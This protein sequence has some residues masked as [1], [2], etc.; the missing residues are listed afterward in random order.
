MAGYFEWHPPDNDDPI[1]FNQQKP[2]LLRDRNLTASNVSIQQSQT[3]PFQV[4]ASFLNPQIESRTFALSV[5]IADPDGENV[6]EFREELA[7]K[8]IVEPQRDE[9]PE[10]GRLV[11]KGGFREFDLELK[12]LPIN[13]PQFSQITFR[14]NVID[15]DLEFFAPYPF[16]TKLEDETAQ[17]ELTGGLEFPLEFEIEFEKFE[18]DDFVINNQGEFKT[19]VIIRVYAFANSVRI[20][21]KTTNEALKFNG[22]IPDGSFLEINTSFGEK[23]VEFVDQETGERRNAIGNLSLSESDF[24]QLVKGENIIGFSLVE[25]SPEQVEIIWRERFIGV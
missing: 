17:V 9:I 25:G 23:S 19:P 11:Y 16:W 3:A 12:C 22:V 5:R 20:E 8:M 7:R 10:L 6:D 15:C 24:W 21:N 4:G 1:I 2:Y 13:S 18:A 14:N